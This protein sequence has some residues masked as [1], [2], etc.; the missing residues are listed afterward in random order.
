ML[1]L[2]NDKIKLRAIE[3]E[4]MDLLYEWE[5]DRSLWEVSNT[6]V[7]FSKYTLKKYLENSHLDLYEAKQLRLMIVE[8]EKNK[9]VGAIDLF[10]FEPFHSRVGIGILVYDK[11]D[12]RKNF[13]SE[14]L[15]IIINYCFNTLMLHQLYCNITTDNKSS[16]DLFTKQGFIIA[17]EK[18]DWIRVCNKWKSEYFLQL[19]N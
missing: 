19:I 2:E 8:N 16:L 10:D 6:L 4:D 14:A 13:A 18:K 1:I 9:T 5:N 7:P 15:N 11:N 17:G 3:P 12:R